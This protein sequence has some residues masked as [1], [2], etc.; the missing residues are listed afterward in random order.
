MAADDTPAFG[1]IGLQKELALIMDHERFYFASFTLFISIIT[2][3][4][5]ETMI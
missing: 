4:E 5:K 1:D 3:I 2:L